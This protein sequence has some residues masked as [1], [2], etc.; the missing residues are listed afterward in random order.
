MHLTGPL[1]L[2]DLVVGKTLDSLYIL[3]TSSFSIIFNK[4][5]SHIQRHSTL[6]DNYS[7]VLWHNR[8]GHAPYH[9]LQRLSLSDLD[10]HVSKLTL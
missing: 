3:E 4:G 1:K 2:S 5:I 9:I 8:F 10:S 7:S 6:K